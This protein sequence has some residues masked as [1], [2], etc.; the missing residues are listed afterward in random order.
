[1]KS[2][3]RLRLAL[4]RIVAGGILTAFAGIAFS[5]A[6]IRNVSKNK[7]HDDPKEVPIRKV[8]L[9]PGCAEILPNGRPNL[10]FRYRIDAASALFRFGRVQYL[11]VSGDNHHRDY[12]EP[13][14]MRD[15]LVANGIP[16]ER[17]YRDYA[18]FRTLDSVIRA[19]EV[20]GQH[21]LT[22]VSQE[23]HNQRAIYIAD[24]HGIDLVGFNAQDVNTAGGLR[25]RL[26]EYLAGV[27]TVLDATILRTR[28]RLL[29]PKVRIGGPVT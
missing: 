24:R 13:T 16:A 26:R 15:A 5:Q 29:G 3:S 22:I 12:D 27:K 10:Y 9:I 23:F 7:T 1:M 25:T 28:P 4:R 8:A 20:F 2:P 18:G 21:T 19:K 14:D 17:I 6:L 11:I